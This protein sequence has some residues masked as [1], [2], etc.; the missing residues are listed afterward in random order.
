MS[1]LIIVTSVAGHAS[2]A[3]LF[4]LLS[5]F[6][7]FLCSNME[8]LQGGLGPAFRLSMKHDKKPKK[9]GN[10]VMSKT[11]TDKENLHMR[12]SCQEFKNCQRR[13]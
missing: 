2:P 3:L 5:L 9:E 13:I 6:S 8:R 11:F 4:L 7:C 1:D 12:H 10:A